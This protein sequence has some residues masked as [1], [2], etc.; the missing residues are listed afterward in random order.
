MATAKIYLLTIY[1]CALGVQECYTPLPPMKFNTHYECVKNGMGE[2]YE[3]LF[4]GRLTEEVINEKNLYISFSC[5][6]EDVVES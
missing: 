5:V 4:N 1:L 3:I 6:P 2:G